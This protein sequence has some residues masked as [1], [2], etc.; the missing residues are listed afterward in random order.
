MAQETSEHA[1]KTDSLNLIPGTP[2]VNSD[3]WSPT[4]I[5]SDPYMLSRAQVQQHSLPQT[6]YSQIANNFICHRPSF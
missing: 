2:V 6:D 3:R 1:M 5:S 4:K